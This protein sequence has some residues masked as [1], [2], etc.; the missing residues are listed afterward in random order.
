MQPMHSM[1]GFDMS[2]QRGAEGL[3]FLHAL[4]KD[5]ASQSPNMFAILEKAVSDELSRVLTES[6]I[7]EGNTDRTLEPDAQVNLEQGSAKSDDS[8]RWP[9]DS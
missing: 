1:Q 2:E 3:M 5:F 6:K 4:S 8:S 7:V 9:T